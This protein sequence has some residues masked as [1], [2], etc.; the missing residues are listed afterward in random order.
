VDEP[1]SA[2]R[3]S[4]G[5]AARGDLGRRREGRLDGTQG[6]SPMVPMVRVPEKGAMEGW[7]NPAKVLRPA[8]LATLK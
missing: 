8:R 1:R 4:V 6:S 3:A 2:L 5:P 7:A